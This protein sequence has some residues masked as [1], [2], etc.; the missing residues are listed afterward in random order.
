[1]NLL[2]RITSIIYTLYVIIT[3]VAVMLLIFPFVCLA[4]LLGKVKGGNIICNLCRFW[5]DV[6]LFL[7]GISHK[8]I[9]VDKQIKNQSVIYIF[10][11]ISYMDI[12]I[13]LKAF[14][15]EPIRILAKSELG[16]VPIFGYIYRQ[17]TVMV[18]RE[19]DIARVQSVQQLKKVLAKNISIVIAP[20][21]TFNLT[22]KPLKEFY[23]GAFKIAFETDTP[24][25]PVVF[26]DAYKRMHYGSIF[27][28]SPGK[29]RAVFLPIILPNKPVEELKQAAYAAMEKTIIAYNCTWVKKDD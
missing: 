17:A 20:E 14:R 9:F 6:C 26:L 29:S 19:S 4:S 21:G 13:L 1:M 8:N 7:W 10:N 27:S 23:N 28:I 11:H 22:N 24:I 3:F 5:A 18:N 2:R 25:Q 15:K 12:P 16:K